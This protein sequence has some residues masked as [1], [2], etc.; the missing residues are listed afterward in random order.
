MFKKLLT[1]QVAKLAGMGIG[2]I[3][4]AIG[5]LTS[6]QQLQPV[7]ERASDYAAKTV[8]LYCELPLIDRER[9]RMEVHERLGEGYVVRV[10][11]LG[12]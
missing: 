2:A 4:A 6:I 9:F 12:D 1:R 5:G 10:D 3:L 8:K 11:C 7:V